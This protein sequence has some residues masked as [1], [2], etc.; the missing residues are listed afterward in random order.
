MTSD[1]FC[2]PKTCHALPEACLALESISKAGFSNKL[3][4]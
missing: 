4:L 1:V 3:P 2:P